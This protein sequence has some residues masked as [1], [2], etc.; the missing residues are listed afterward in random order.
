MASRADAKRD[1]LAVD[2]D[3]AG[4]GLVDAEQHARDLGP[5][6]AD[7]TAEPEHLAAW[8]LRSMSRKAAGARKPLASSTSAPGTAWRRSG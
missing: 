1:R 2:Q 4:V 5:A 3:L 7:Q 6:A 8:S